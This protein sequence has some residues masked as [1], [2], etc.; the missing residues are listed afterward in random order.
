MRLESSDLVEISSEPIR[1][2]GPELLH[3]LC[4]KD[5]KGI[6]LGAA[7]LSCTGFIARNGTAVAQDIDVGEPRMTG[8]GA[9]LTAIAIEVKDVARLVTMMAAALPQLVHAGNANARALATRRACG[10]EARGSLAHRFICH[11]THRQSRQG[12]PR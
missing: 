12:R 3:D 2:F 5:V 7:E 9:Q 6:D 4:Q 1:T 10:L 11:V 8:H